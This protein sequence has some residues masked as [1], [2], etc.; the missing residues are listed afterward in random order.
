M[1]FYIR[2]LTSAVIYSYSPTDFL[3]SAD[4]PFTIFHR[5]NSFPVISLIPRWLLIGQDQILSQ[6]REFAVTD[7]RWW[8]KRLGSGSTRAVILSKN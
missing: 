2:L 3:R 6:A 7:P 1:P 5:A 4:G 8:M